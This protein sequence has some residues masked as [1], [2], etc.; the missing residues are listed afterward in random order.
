M[1]QLINSLPQATSLGQGAAGDSQVSTGRS[2]ACAATVQSSVFVAKPLIAA[3]GRT[4]DV[5]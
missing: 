4:A 5:C 1:H 3:G 2:P